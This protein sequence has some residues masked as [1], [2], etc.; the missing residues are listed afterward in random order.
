[1]P[2]PPSARARRALLLAA[3]L[4]PA[5]CDERGKSPAPPAT[6]TT[7]A[8]TTGAGTAR[9]LCDYTIVP[10]DRI[11][12]AG[13]DKTL[14]GTTSVKVDIEQGRSYCVFGGVL[15]SRSS[16]K[17]AQAIAPPECKSNVIVGAAQLECEKAGIALSFAGP[18]GLFRQVT[19]Y[20]PAR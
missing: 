16:L 5:A 11:T 17:D 9:P 6:A 15:T 1:M 18:P 7:P 13:P 19:I 20:P 3:L 4:A 10:G 12:G 2:F 14:A 8:G